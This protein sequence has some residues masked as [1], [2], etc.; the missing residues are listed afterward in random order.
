MHHLRLASAAQLLINEFSKCWGCFLELQGEAEAWLGLGNIIPQHPPQRTSHA[1]IQRPHVASWADP[2]CGPLGPCKVEECSWGM[3]PAGP[4]WAPFGWIW[5]SDH[6]GQ[7]G[8]ILLAGHLGLSFPHH[9]R[10]RHRQN[11]LLRRTLN[12]LYPHSEARAQGLRGRARGVTFRTV[13][14]PFGGRPTQ[15]LGCNRARAAEKRSCLLEPRLLFLQKH[16]AERLVK[17]QEV[18]KGH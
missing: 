4:A 17:S 9:C 16:F 3:E 6:G 2:P 8:D 18:S 5:P 12:V 14:W 15:R 13:P 1:P 11:W 7:G 10:R